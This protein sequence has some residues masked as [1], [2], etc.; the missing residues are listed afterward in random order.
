MIK[1]I[2]PSK[3]VPRKR[4]KYS[5]INIIK[6]LIKNIFGIGGKKNK[7]F[8]KNDRYR[9]NKQRRKYHAKNFKNRNKAQ[10]NSKSSN[11]TRGRRNQNRAKN[12]DYDKHKKQNDLTETQ[13][14]YQI[15]DGNIQQ[16]NIKSPQL[17]STT[18]NSAE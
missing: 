8:K 10:R 11:Q 9:G 3:P 4:K 17:E 12:S 14:K 15:N 5:I 1:Q 13:S 6:R 18:P 7:K 2:I 16:S